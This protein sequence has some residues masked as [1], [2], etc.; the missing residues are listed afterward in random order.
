MKRGIPKEKLGECVIFGKYPHWFST[1][2]FSANLAN[3]TVNNGTLTLFNSP[4][5]I[6]GI[7]CWHVINDYLIRV[8]KEKNLIFQIG[9]NI[10]RPENIL[11]DYNQELDL[12]TLRLSKEML[13][14]IRGKSDPTMGSQYIST[15]YQ[16]D[17][18]VGDTIILGGLPGKWVESPQQ[19]FMRFETFS[20]GSYKVKSASLNHYACQLDDF[21]D[22]PVQET[23]FKHRPVKELL[24]PGG[25][26]GGPVF[27]EVTSEAGLMHLELAGIIY[28]GSFP[29]QSTS[30]VLLI[31]PAKFIQID[32][33][34][35]A[36]YT[37][38][39]NTV[40]NKEKA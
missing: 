8:E 29:M 22:W 10:V 17:I 40:N 34:I 31:R 21:N 37:N 25:L 39:C 6:I 27:V 2:I 18:K 16:N 26:S 28:E 35:K 32:G 7:T 14:R 24:H 12:A 1:P 9:E 3:N 30:L 5:G 15:I 33:T 23:T 38:Y 19:G 11:I 36:D 4:N 20:I 13:P